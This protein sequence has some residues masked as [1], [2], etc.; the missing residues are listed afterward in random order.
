MASSSVAR[1][2]KA[3]QAFTKTITLQLDRR[4]DLNNKG[5]VP[6]L[7]QHQKMQLK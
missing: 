2:L 1:L 5:L 3:T 6:V 4:A 7:S